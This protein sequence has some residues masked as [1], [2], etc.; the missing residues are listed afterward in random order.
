MKKKTVAALLIVT[1]ALLLSLTGCYGDMVTISFDT[2]GGNTLPSISV[3]ASATKLELPVP[4]KEG[5]QFSYWCYDQEGNQRVDTSVIPDENTTFYAKWTAKLITVTF[6]STNPVTQEVTRQYKYVSYGGNLSVE[7]MPEIAD[8]SGYEGIWLSGG[9]TSVTAPQTIYARFSIKKYSVKYYVD[10]EEYAS[11]LGEP[12]TVIS[13]PSAPTKEGYYFAGWYYSEEYTSRLSNPLTSIPVQSVSLHARFIDISESSRFFNYIT[14]QGNVI[15]VGLT[16]VGKAQKEIVIPSQINGDRVSGI[17]FSLTDTSATNL[18]VFQSTIL[19]TVV[20]PDTVRSIGNFAFY[21]A[22]NLKEV[23]VEGNNLVTIGI[24]AFAGC[25]SLNSFDLP[26]SVTNIGKYCFAGMSINNSATNGITFNG[27]GSWSVVDKWANVDMAFSTMNIPSDSSLSVINNYAFY[28]LTNLKQITLPTTLTSLNYLAF[29]NSGIEYVDAFAG[30]NFISYQ[31]AVYSADGKTLIYYPAKGAAGFALKSGTTAIASYAFY[32]NKNITTVTSGASLITIGAYA[33]YQ[34]EN[35]ESIAL[36]DN[37]TLTT[38]GDYA[39]SKS[40]LAYFNFPTSFSSLGKGAFKNSTNLSAA[41]FLGQSISSIS[42]E[43]FY[44]CNKLAEITIPRSV[45]IIGKNA[46]FGCTQLINVTFGEN[47]V[48]NTIDDYAFANC[49]KI[50][51][52]SLPTSIRTINQYAFAGIS[53]KMNLDLSSVPS[54]LITLGDYA[55]SNTKLSNFTINSNLRNWGKGVFKNCTSLTRFTITISEY[56]TAIP[57]ETLYGCTNLAQIVFPYTILEIKPYALYN[58]TNLSDVTFSLSSFNEGITTIGES[59]FENC[60]SLKSGDAQ[61]RILPTTLTSIGERAFYNCSKITAIYIPS[62]LNKLSKQAFANCTTLTEIRYDTNSILHTIG[63]EAFAKCTALVSARLPSSLSPRIGED[64]G[65]VKNPFI[66]CTSLT[67]FILD[68]SINNLTVNNGVVYLNTPTDKIIYMYPTGKTGA[69]VV[70]PDVTVIDQYSFYGA[71]VGS[72]TFPSNPAVEGVETIYLVRIGAYAFGMSQLSTVTLSKRVYLIEDYAF[73]MSSVST[74]SIDSAYVSSSNPG[75]HIVNEGISSNALSINYGAFFNSDIANLALPERTTNIG[76]G[77]FAQCY[78]MKTLTFSGSDNFVLTIGDNAFFGNSGLKSIVFPRQITSIGNYAFAN[79]YN[80]NSITFNYSESLGI[81]LSLGDYA[82]AN[83]HYLYSIRLP[84]HLESLGEGEFS[85]NSRLTEVIFAPTIN[86]PSLVLPKLAFFGSNSLKTINLPG[87]I[88]EIGEKA[89]WKTKLE[90]I[91]LNNGVDVVICDY[92]FSETAN[93][94]NI[95]FTENVTTIGDYAFYNS[96][97]EAFTFSGIGKDIAIHSYAFY[98]AP[99]KQI[100][101]TS[102][103]KTL[104]EYAFANTT[105]LT[106]A[107][108]EEGIIAIGNYAFQ[109]SSIVSI[110][111]DSSVTEIGDYAFAYTEKLEGISGNIEIIGDYAFYHS[112]IAYFYTS[113]VISSLSIG[114]RSFSFCKNLTSIDLQTSGTAQ[115]GNFA[116]ADSV[117]LSELNIIGNFASIGMGITANVAALDSINIIDNVGNYICIDGVLYFNEGMDLILVQYPIGRL[118]STYT[119][120][121]NI[122]G[123]EDYAFQ[124]NKTLLSIIIKGEIVPEKGANSFANTNSKLKIYVAE[125][126]IEDY[127]QDWQIDNIT[128]VTE[129]L[130]G[131][132]LKYVGSDNYSIIDYTGTETNLIIPGLITVGS[133]ETAISYRLIYIEEYAFANSVDL[134]SI[135][136]GS[137]I[138]EIHDYAFNN[139]IRL[140]SVNLGNNLLTIKNYS[141]YGC[142]SLSNITFGASLVSIGNYAFQNCPSLTEITLPNSVTS[143]GN[144]AF[145]KA[146][147]LSNIT[148]GNSLQYLG[149]NAFEYNVNIV[150]ITL[151]GSLSS[152]SDNVFYGCDRL[153]YIYLQSRQ[154]PK[155]K[156]LNAFRNTP[157]SLQ[158]FVS[159]NSIN[160]YISD[161]QW[162]NFSSRILSVS[163]I[164]SISEDVSYAVEKINGNNYR[165]LSYIGTEENITVLSNVSAEIKIVEIGRRAF[166]HFAKTIILSEGITAL[167]KHSF[168]NAKNLTSI[169]LPSS[170]TNIG[171]NSFYSLEKLE[172]VVFSDFSTSNLTTIGSYAFYNTIKM[173]VFDFPAKL[174]TIGDYAFA[175]TGNAVL[176]EI[177]FHIPSYRSIAL[178][179]YSFANNPLIKQITFN[180]AVTSLGEGTFSNCT[181]LEAIYFNSLGTATQINSGYTKVFENCYKLS[182]FV[183]SNSMYTGFYNVWSNNADRSKLTLASNIAKDSGEIT[184]QENFVIS[185]NSGSNTASIIN[186]IGTNT[187]VTFP[188]T[189]TINQNTY[190][191]TKI[192]REAGSTDVISG[193]VIGSNVTK[194]II[195]PTVTTIAADAFRNSASLAIVEIASGSG[196]ESIGKNA[197]ANCQNL[198]TINITKNISTIDS[199]AFNNCVKLTNI[200]FENRA[201]ND[202]VKKLVIMDRVFY[203]C[204]ALTSI[205]LPLHIDV[206]GE[207]SF[208]NCTKLNNVV[209]TEDHK[210]TRLGKYALSYTAIASIYL[211]FSVNSVDDYCFVG[212]NLLRR[213]YLNRETIPGVSSSLTSAGEQVFGANSSPFIKV[214][215]PTTSHTSY[216][217]TKWNVKTIIPN[218]SQGEFN[219]IINPSGAEN[220]VTL[221]NYLGSSTILNVPSS[222]QINNVEHRVTTLGRYFGNE[223]ITEVR[224]AENNYV[225]AFESYSFA[226]CTS[227]R[228]IHMPSN[229]T[230]IGDYSFYNCSALADVI[231]PNNL[232]NI[233]P[234]VFAN[235]TS[236][237]EIAITPQV[238]TIGNFAFIGCT[239]LNRV[240]VNIVIADSVNA[241]GQNAFSNTSPSLVILV[242]ENDL[243]KYETEWRLPGII[244]KEAMAGDFV[245]RRNNQGGYSLVQ[246]NGNADIDLTTLT[247]FG[248]KVNEILVNSITDSQVRITIDSNTTYY[249]AIQDRITIID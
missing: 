106:S 56:I 34:C 88:S 130:N 36:D 198:T 80:V 77:A 219:Y 190:T 212:S 8:I 49:T 221:T 230:T 18:S 75:Y 52:V 203:G 103:I 199:S 50:A 35:L 91:T 13:S 67:S 122:L 209:L 131:F 22:T 48:L 115:V 145:S 192:G 30:G 17:G 242:N 222:I 211:P 39:F 249:A 179:N 16:S 213:V 55:F 150:S 146:T 27:E 86:A 109:N 241:L 57:E 23:I 132:V 207:Y 29:L 152:I 171:D 32:D 53:G 151:P 129:E 12:Q 105:R 184:G 164:I 149:N 51:T 128:Y 236:L 2:M 243:S 102:R 138:K 117:N 172:T 3:S 112:G 90:N 194:V 231:L 224:F 154:A 193:Y 45:A 185:V 101:L 182:V 42:D 82:F 157:E 178:G 119:L 94:K 124:G 225:T 100:T 246:Y 186:Y 144:Y 135:T 46:F 189:V 234:Y 160:N 15:I 5:Y 175:K 223:K 204:V 218:L 59:A 85:N 98:G 81:S 147:S 28:N 33:F 181:N 20:I 11:Y 180:C 89:F 68:N 237:K 92:A 177:N 37:T 116:F 239:S 226:A 174:Q 183:A 159:A 24:G 214:Y 113:G 215:T 9:L 200:S 41:S 104:G 227:L 61:K 208:A 153:T 205:T 58:C 238:I 176:A 161:N 78:D 235:C 168:A 69:F 217:S 240:I 108:I 10:G 162:R 47:S 191:I 25:T 133:G 4:E 111:L 83:N 1:F 93:L 173:A 66:G 64:I 114:T 170:L 87:Y 156:S 248:G 125:D 228:K 155:L 167:N 244:S 142:L 229:I 148:L 74:L 169:I 99:L 63:E 7:E 40:K 73:A 141:F 95:H 96:A 76:E 120:P 38:I 118:S 26:S 62:G 71:A 43:A 110:E 206:I 97:L 165:L 195:P 220:T 216:Q 197:F 137:G 188:S 19:E 158:F 163:S 134:L 107:I 140:E 31:G 136:I 202:P 196:L 54:E 14:D 79:C 166:G 127:Q 121:L 70:N 245:V 201:T 84:N 187:I 233:Q 139:C 143:L 126:L 44:A 21:G 60:T 6:V 65:L 210:V 123:I 247:F 72:I 232:N